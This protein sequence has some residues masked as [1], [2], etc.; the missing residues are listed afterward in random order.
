MG[1][2][3]YF[4]ECTC[5]WRYR[6]FH[7]IVRSFAEKLARFTSDECDVLVMDKQEHKC[8]TCGSQLTLP[9]LETFDPERDPEAGNKV[10]I[11]KDM[12]NY[13]DRAIEREETVEHV[14][15]DWLDK[16]DGEP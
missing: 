7:P 4:G 11:L 12:E 14:M 15:K 1:S 10:R 2:L 13:L 16:I 5:G 6:A 3:I 8:S 9:L